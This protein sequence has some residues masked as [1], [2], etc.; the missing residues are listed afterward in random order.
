MREESAVRRL[1]KVVRSGAFMPAIAVLHTQIK[2]TAA[3]EA[4]MLVLA[5]LPDA[6]A[7]AR[8]DGVVWTS[9]RRIG[10]DP[11]VCAADAHRRFA[12]QRSKDQDDQ[13]SGSA[14]GIP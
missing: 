14:P 4:A 1:D 6:L 8:R 7:V 10:A 2:R 12:K 3:L 11:E 13:L 5:K 9:E